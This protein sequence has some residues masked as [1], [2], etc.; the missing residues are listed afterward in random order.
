VA[1]GA[2]KVKVKGSV[3][4][5]FRKQS[6]LEEVSLMLCGCMTW[7]GVGYAAKVDGRMDGDLY[8]QNL[9]D[10]LQHTLQFYGLNPPDIIFQKDND[11]KHTSKKVMQQG[12]RTMSWLTQSPALSPIEHL[13]SYHK[14]RLAE[15]EIASTWYERVMEE[16]AGRVDED[17]R[18]QCAK[19]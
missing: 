13:W 7:N 4:D 16:S 8:F 9:M 6:N 17:T 12:F 5:W 11:R 2:G 19:S 15:Y 18:A 3:T 14:L 1:S 10:E